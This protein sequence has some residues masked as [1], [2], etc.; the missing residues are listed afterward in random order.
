MAT[1]P[2]VRR[3]QLGNELR[4]AREAAGLTL[5]DAADCIDGSSSRISR[6]ELAQTK[7]ALGDVKLLMELYG[8]G[9]EHT[10]ALVALARNNTSRGRWSG[11]RAVH[12]DWYRTY[13]D[14]ETDADTIRAVGLE[15][16]PGLLQT[17]DYI[18]ALLSDGGRVED[19]ELITQYA[20]ARLERQQAITRD[21][22]AQVSFVIS[23]S[24]LR[25]KIGRDNA[26]MQGQLEHLAEVGR[27]P[28]VQIQVLPFDSPSNAAG[29]VAYRF[30]VLTIP[31]AGV[32]PPLDFV[33]LEDYDDARYLD[34]RQ[35][36]QLYLNLWG[37]LQAAALDP[38]ESLT[39]IREAAEDYR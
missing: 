34:T 4:R 28:N 22:P 31:S 29:E 2:T 33:Y 23:E 14:L 26:V 21:D 12:R 18:R 27:R 9:K 6:I 39:F 16:I 24:S 32:A 8:G 19:D 5:D 7:I 20:L 17:E 35:G 37:R 11:H 10:D 38:A 3:L 1:T 36:V 25:R 15:V 13:V 30:T